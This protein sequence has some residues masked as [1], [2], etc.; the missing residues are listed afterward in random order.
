MF[1]LNKLV[2]VHPFCYRGRRQPAVLNFKDRGGREEAEKNECLWVLKSP[3]HRYLHEGGGGGLTMFPV[4][5]D[6]VK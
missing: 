6:F 5:K 3:G 1:F 2:S 4:K